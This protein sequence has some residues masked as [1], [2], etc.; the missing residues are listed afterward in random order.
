MVVNF[1]F[2]PSFL[3]SNNVRVCIQCEQCMR[4]S[5]NVCGIYDNCGYSL[6]V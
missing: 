1:F 3:S 6:G 4:Y 2:F 5:D